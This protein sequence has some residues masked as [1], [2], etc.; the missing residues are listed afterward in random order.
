MEAESEVTIALYR[1]MPYSVYRVSRLLRRHF[2]AL[3]DAKGF[4]LTPEQWFVLNK[5]RTGGAKSQSS[6]GEAVLGDRANMTRILATM[7][8]KGLVVQRVDPVDGRKCRV[9]VTSLGG[10]VHDGFSEVD[11]AEQRQVF[12]GINEL[13]IACVM[14]VLAQLGTNIVE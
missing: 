11:E 14:K 5:L 1:S 7:S 12:E 8:R 4:D 6:L 3:A 2:L 13:D 9:F 10:R